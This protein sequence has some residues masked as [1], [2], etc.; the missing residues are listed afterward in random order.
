MNILF[1]SDLSGMGGGETSLLHIMKYLNQAEHNVILLCRTEGN[2]TKYTRESG[3]TTYVIDYKSKKEM[4]SREI[5]DIIKRHEIG[6]IHSNE[7]SSAILFGIENWIYHLK[8]QNVCTCHGQWYKLSNIRKSAI[9][10]LVDHIF[11]VSKAVENNLNNQGIVNTSVSYLGVPDQI[12]SKN[13]RFSAEKKAELYNCNESDFVIITIGRFQVIKGQ[14]KGVQAIEQ[15]LNTHPNINYYLIG[16]TIFGDQKDY[17]YKEEVINY[18]NNHRLSEHIHLMGERRD[19][20][21]LLSTCDLVMITSDNESF[22]M[23]AIE[24][25]ESGCPIIS[26]PCDGPKEIFGGD[27]DILTEENTVLS[28]THSICK[29]C[30]DEEYRKRILNKIGLLAGKFSIGTVV[31]HYKKYY[32]L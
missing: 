14:L 13:N 30:E 26:T 16:D 9:R 10:K 17:E 18:I 20:P 21:K 25:I 22:G 27:G 8:I 2:L 7:L 31:N 1:T 11:C 24:A 12:Y 23:V 3:I 29:Y 32:E 6:I 19:I 4:I 15:S 5:V 28:L